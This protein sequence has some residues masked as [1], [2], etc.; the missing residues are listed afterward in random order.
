MIEILAFSNKQ[1]SWGFLFISFYCLGMLLR[2]LS[3]L[4]RGWP[5]H[6]DSQRGIGHSSSCIG[7]CPQYNQIL[8]SLYYLDIKIS[9]RP[10]RPYCSWMCRFL[11]KAQRLHLSPLTSSG[12]HLPCLHTRTPSQTLRLAAPVGGWLPLPTELHSVLRRFLN[13]SQ[14]LLLQSSRMVHNATKFFLAFQHT[15]CCNFVHLAAQPCNT[16]SYL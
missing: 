9:R 10:R 4:F 11:P 5:P 13:S 6:T 14:D 12:H 2:K 3:K 16:S 7:K 15:A 1:T 8:Y